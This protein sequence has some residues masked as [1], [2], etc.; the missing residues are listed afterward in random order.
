RLREQ[1]TSLGLDEEVIFHGWVD[2]AEVQSQMRHAHFLLLTSEIEGMS[3][4]GLQAYRCGLPII[5][6]RVPGL[7]SFVKPGE[8]GYLVNPQL[9]DLPEIIR[10]TALNPEISLKMAP[11]CQQMIREKYSIKVSADMYLSALS[12]IRSRHE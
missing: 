12:T 1:A 6:T 5:A 2:T 8:T 9:D 3:N 11:A 10:R 4:A 7:E